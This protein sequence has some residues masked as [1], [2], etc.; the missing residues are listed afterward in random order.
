MGLTENSLV[1]CKVFLQNPITTEGGGLMISWLGG[2]L[3]GLNLAASPYLKEELFFA[4]NWLDY[5]IL[6]A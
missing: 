4:C 5:G 6:H 2:F 1:S 3:S